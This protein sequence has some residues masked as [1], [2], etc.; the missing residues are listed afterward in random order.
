MIVASRRRRHER[1]FIIYMTNYIFRTII[2]ER[3]MEEVQKVTEMK[4]V[5]HPDNGTPRRHRRRRHRHRHHHHRRRHQHHFPHRLFALI[6][7]QE[8]NFNLDLAEIY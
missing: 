1:L 6:Y 8:Q 4:I 2:R 5:Q 3:E 7:L